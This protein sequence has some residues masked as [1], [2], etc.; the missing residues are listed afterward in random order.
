LS[1]LGKISG[2]ADSRGSIS[3]ESRRDTDPVGEFKKELKARSLSLSEFYN[4]EIIRV[5]GE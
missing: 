4:S 5:Y 3:R 1:A 2:Q